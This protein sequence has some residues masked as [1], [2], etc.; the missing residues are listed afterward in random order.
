MAASEEQK[1]TKKT[2]RHTHK[3]NIA[4][5]LIFQPNERLLVLEIDMNRKQKCHSNG[6][7]LW[8]V[9]HGHVRLNKTYNCK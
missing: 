1:N 7:N 6:A 8:Y 9:L 3:K 5:S 4:L 2:Q